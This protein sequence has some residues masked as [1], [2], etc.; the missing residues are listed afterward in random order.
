MGRY[1]LDTHT[2]L[3]HFNGGDALSQTARSIMW[4]YS[5]AI[6]MSMVSAWELAIKITIGKL[7]FPGNS[8]G[9]IQ[10]AKANGIKLLPIE[11]A[12]LAALEEL[13]LIHRDPFD[14]LL[15]ATAQAERLTLITV[16]GKIARYDVPL[17]W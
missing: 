9:F 10:I 6:Y 7:R 4:D 17:V 15:I 8:A 16:D 2:A 13:P 3:W 1:L 12:H 11:A 14:R 5:N